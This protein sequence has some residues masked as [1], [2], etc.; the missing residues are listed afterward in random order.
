MSENPNQVL[1]RKL[2]FFRSERGWSQER[3][4]ERCGLHRTYIG[5]VERGERNVT[6]NTLMEI[7]NAFGVVPAELISDAGT[8]SG[9]RPS[10]KPART[11]QSR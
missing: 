11:N 10:K 1:A 9:S 3:F 2:R 6:L 5:A 4:A 7:A 8:P